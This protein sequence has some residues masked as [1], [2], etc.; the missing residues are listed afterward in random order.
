M[1][2]IEVAIA[3]AE[4]GA[5]VIRGMYGTA[6]GRHDKSP[7]DF[8]TDADLAAEK[9]IGEVIRAA[10]PD[11]AVVGEEFGASGQGDRTWLIDPLCGTLNFAAQ[12]PLFSV[13]IALR[14]GAETVVAAVADPL[15]GEIFWTAGTMAALRRDGIDSQLVPSATS[16]LVDVDADAPRDAVLLPAD[17]IDRDFRDVFAPRIS[18]TTLTLAWTAAGRRAAYVSNGILR[19]SVHFTPGI[20]LCQAAGCIVTDLRGA[21]LHTGPGLVAAADPATH[22]QL[23][24]FIARRL[25]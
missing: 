16:R 11:D 22:Q 3:A 13:N 21:P 12:T 8:A 23:L 1:D 10:R 4:A 17:L 5:A 19:D 7:T 15:A 9:A 2:D 25:V 6:V 14:S 24:E 20:A 18:S